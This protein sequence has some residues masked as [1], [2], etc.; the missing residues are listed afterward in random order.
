MLACTE[1]LCEYR[2]NPIGIDEPLPRF[3]WKL[4]SDKENV[5]Q[6]AYEIK[7]DGM[8]KSGK[9]ESGQSVHLVYDGAPLQPYT[10]YRYAVR[11]WDNQGEV[12]DWTEGYF[13]MGLM[14]NKNW[15]ASWI[16]APEG[17]GDVLPVF[18]KKFILDGDITT[19]RMYATALGNYEI[20]LNGQRVG[21][22]WLAPGFTSYNKHL[23]YQTYDITPLLKREN[24]LCI[25]L[26]KGWCRGRIAWGNDGNFFHCKPGI[27]AQLRIEREDGTVQTIATDDTWQY[28]ESPYRFSEIYDGETYDANLEGDDNRNWKPVQRL[29][30]PLSHISAQA[31]EPVRITQRIQPV[32]LLKTPKGETVIDFGQNMVGWAECKVSGQRGD[33]VLLSFGEVLDKEGNFY[34]ENYRS[35]KN[36]VEYILS[37]KGE[38]CYHPH[39][40]FQGFRYVRVD[41]F[42][43]EA[44]LENFTGVVIHSDFKR[45]GTFRCGNAEINQL[46]QNT[47]WGQRGNFVD[48]PTDCPQRDERLGW[49]GDA[50]VFIKTAALNYQVGPF[51]EKWLTDLRLDQTAEQGVPHV[52]P[53]VFGPQAPDTWSS[54]AWGDAA[55]IC[56]WE[57]YRAYGDKRILE[58]QYESM[59]AW[60]DYIRAQGV[61][62]A[63]WNTGFH[64]GDWLAMDAAEGSYRGRTAEDFIA[65]VFFAHSTR[66]V[67]KTAEVLGKEEEATA[68]RELYEKIRSSFREEFVTPRGRLTEDTQTAYVLALHFD[69]VE[70]RSRAIER[71]TELVQ[72]N[73]GKL[74]TGFV[75]T[76]YLCHAL[77]DNGQAEL[78]Y[79][80]VLQTEYP[81]WLYSVR[82]G[83]TTI[84]EHWDGIKPDGTFWSTAM[85]SYNHYAYGSVVDWMYT[86]A[87]GIQY[88][89]SAPGYQKIF[90]R[91]VP[92]KRF[93]FVEA[94]VDTVYGVVKS[95]WKYEG[96]SIHFTVT[97]PPNTTA[98]FEAPGG[99]QTEL[100]SGT[101]QF[102]VVL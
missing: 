6:T 16:M 72:Q 94:S 1:L 36:R 53:N 56:P 87:A 92:D 19:A 21:D 38:E 44:T 67:S 90:F 14:D 52:I 27:L 60:V 42:P 77:T 43:G 24:T 65:T 12:S 7:V 75:G 73:D 48:V 83:A 39:F 40:T 82:Q 93:G 55:T 74:T 84:W 31:H 58:R 26:A 79:S 35:A 96:D 80:L 17:D 47:L 91:P 88:D 51:F 63:L 3:S 20:T 81:S 71:L 95:A 86:K 29:Q 37:G 11:V 18:Q 62:E 4:E 25:T 54:S 66:L 8:W 5:L 30:Y 101:H 97:V 57:I 59:R 89:E 45:T 78:A 23:L 32:E 49:T 68:Y 15:T 34:N 99:N 33:R 13:E 10:R 41:A 9:V 2:T 46:Y 64:Y 76:P 28:A 69:L 22:A 102:Q 98:V 50:Q 100:G 70:N 85:N 61:E